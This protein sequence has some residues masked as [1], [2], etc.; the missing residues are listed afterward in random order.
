MKCSTIETPGIN[1]NFEPVQCR[2][3]VSIVYDSLFDANLLYLQIHDVSTCTQ[4]VL[5]LLYEVIRGSKR[6]AD[7][8]YHSV[9]YAEWTQSIEQRLNDFRVLSHT[10]EGTRLSIEESRAQSIELYRL[11]ALIYLERASKSFSGRSEKVD[12][13]V[14]Q[15]FGILTHLLTCNAALPL[16]I[17]GLEART[18]KN[19]RVILDLLEDTLQTSQSKSLE[20]VRH[21]MQEAWI[22]DDLEIDVDLDYMIKLDTIISANHT[23][24]A[25]A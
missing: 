11:G 19:R 14:E 2:P 8:A 13:L 20:V 22:Q 10:E 5:R 4:E 25:F 15:A 7:P 12:L 18:D 6:A 24:P 1:S 9:L 17:V 16:F 21:M 23:V 3:H